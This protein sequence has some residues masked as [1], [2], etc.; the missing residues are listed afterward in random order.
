MT[1]AHNP[2]ANEQALEG[3]REF[4]GKLAATV[5]IGTASL[6]SQALAQEVADE[7]S[8]QNTLNPVSGDT[9]GHSIDNLPISQK[10]EAIDAEI[11]EIQTSLEGFYANEES[12]T[13]TQW[14]EVDRLEIRLIELENQKQELGQQLLAEQEAA[15]DNYDAALEDFAEIRSFL[16]DGMDGVSSELQAILARGDALLD[17]SEYLGAEEEQAL[18]DKIRNITAEAV[19]YLKQPH[20]RDELVKITREMQV[21][22]PQQYEAFKGFLISQDAEF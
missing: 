1:P 10:I 20:H 16:P 9:E 12:L 18:S 6:A 7:S 15:I 3:R 22:D 2:E 19:T 5:A 8:L 17:T 11:A 21:Q 4:L 13:D 14:D